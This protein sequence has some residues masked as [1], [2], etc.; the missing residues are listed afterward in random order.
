MAGRIQR[1]GR[2]AAAAQSP[3]AQS[4]AAP[5]PAAPSPS[6][7]LDLSAP[8]EVRPTPAAPPVTTPAAPAA[9]GA[10][11]P[12]SLLDLSAPAAVPT[13]AA[14]Q[15]PAAPPA[16]GT[17]GEATPWVAGPRAARPTAARNA[18]SP[19]PRA[20]SGTRVIL[21]E[22]DPV[23]SLTR[24]QSGIG[25]LVCEAV[26][27]PAV[28]DVRL[29]AAYQLTDGT[30]SVVQHAAGRSAGP[31][32]S[33]QPLIAGSRDTYDRITVDLRQVRRL[34]RL[35]VYAFSA[36]YSELT[37]GGTLVGTTSTG[38]RIEVPLELGRW[39]GPVVLLSAYNVHGELVLR[40]ERQLVDGGIREA[41]RA[42]GF[43]RIAW[44]DDGTPI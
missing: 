30:S 7:L 13:P 18:V 37:W 15:I 4:P 22:D 38:A 23:V 44:A 19:G 24:L 11:S 21:T 35:V 28:G 20:R 33:R 2:P 29:G 43:D 3:A 41:T 31:P 40:A 34:T 12:S 36:T 39:R 6:S 1:P 16:T 8:A 32:G 42:F 27:S 10:L 17:R 5:S 14:V 26:C 9:A 25:I